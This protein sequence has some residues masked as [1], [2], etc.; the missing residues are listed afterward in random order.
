MVSPGS[1]SPAKRAAERRRDS[2][3]ELLSV[4]RPCAVP[5]LHHRYMDGSAASSAGGV[6]KRPDP[7]ALV[8]RGARLAPMSFAQ[9]R[10]W[11]FEQLHPYRAAYNMASSFRIRGD[12]DLDRLALAFAAVVARHEV[13]RSRFEDKDG[14]GRQVVEPP[15]DVPLPVIDL[16]DEADRE[17]A[18]RRMVRI[19]RTTP[20][21]L[22]K[23]PLLRPS[24]YRLANQEH[25]LNLSVHHI[26]NDGWSYGLLYREVG[27]Y[28]SGSDDLP[29]LPVQFGDFAAWQRETHTPQTLREQLEFW[30]SALAD[31]PMVL[32]LPTDRPRPPLQPTGGAAYRFTLPS[33]LVVS[34]R[35]LAGRTRCTLFMV[36]L[37]ALQVLLGRYSGMERFVVGVPS[38]G[39][40]VPALD[41]LIGL[42]IGVLPVPADLTG[43]PTFEELL[44][45]VR[46]VTL[47]AY[48]H[49]DVPLEMLL[50]ELH[51]PRSLS[52][53]TL[54]QVICQMFEDA[55]RSLNLR[56]AE[57][58]PEPTGVWRSKQDL[59]L[60]FVGRGN[61]FHG[62][63][64]YPPD[65]FD[66]T[67]IQRL[68][69][70]LIAVLREGVAEPGRRL[71]TMTLMDPAERDLVLTNWNDRREGGEDAHCLHE[72]F[73][74]QA[75]RT[76]GA[77]AVRCGSEQVCFGELD[78]RSNRLAHLLA[79][80]GVGPETPV[81]IC[82]DRSIDLVVAILAVLKAG[83]AYVPLEPAYPSLWRR[84]LLRHCAAPIVI[85]THKTMADECQDPARVL[86]L[87]NHEVCRALAS[88]PDQP[89]SVRVLPSALA[90]IIYTSGSTGAPKGVATEHRSVVNRLRWMW[91]EFPFVPDEVC[92]LKTA[93]SFVDSIAEIFGPLLTGHTLVPIPGEDARDTERLLN[94]LGRDGIR[95]IMVVPSLL[96]VLLDTA[97]DLAGR[98]PVLKLWICGGEVLT[99]SLARDF[100]AA[101]P[102]ATLV[103]MYGA[104]ETTVDITYHRVGEADRVPN[105]AIPV[106]RPQTGNRVY[107]LDDSLRPV[108]VGVTGSIYLSGA[109]L[110][111][112][113]YGNPAHTAE[114]F[115]PNPY[116]LPGQRLYHTGDSGRFRPDGAMEFVERTASLAKVR[117]ARVETAHVARVLQEHPGVSEA[118]V[119]IVTRPGARTQLIGYYA[120]R[121][122]GEIGVRA[123]LAERLPDYM[124]PARLVPLELL[125]HLP[126]GK[127]DLRSLLDPEVAAAAPVVETADSG[128]LTGPVAQA[129]CHLLGV[130]VVHRDDNFFTLGGDS[131]TAVRLVARVRAAGIF[132]D[133]RDVFRYLTL[134][135]LDEAW[136]R[137]T[138]ELIALWRGQHS[139]STS[140][141]CSSTAKRLVCAPGKRYSPPTAGNSTLGTGWP[142][143]P[144]AAAR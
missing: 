127:V 7:Q 83:G 6:L 41:E 33:D 17:I 69:A 120:G 8:R 16:R 29:E 27:A 39:R 124:I 51:P 137:R 61:N 37:A 139:S 138:E 36:T 4:R 143:W 125:P 126:N 117:G 78:L 62:L 115:L 134:Q 110:V 79:T 15:M 91:Q 128:T 121:E 3:R 49:A 18:W 30:T 122:I 104:S 116:G 108:P 26:A 87:D 86:F 21:D 98:V 40:P 93:I 66:S 101:M 111:R 2:I 72:M 133:L 53:S 96:R 31:Y 74:A 75:S 100:A 59:S 114:C 55:D 12:L 10:L 52:R 25:V 136:S 13:L 140:T 105:A 68:V 144:Q 135:E 9:E 131:L 24:L 47:A 20:F 58:K 43:D 35:S 65:L 19:E 64:V 107:V 1:L 77:I 102:G 42:F 22:C 129:C 142:R 94:V 95:R 141:D 23:P 89:P 90:Y 34:M 130:K 80:Y 112:G 88:Q 76:P 44:R 54:V 38:V 63:V 103:N 14:Y 57:V 71:S 118:V 5:G 70:H 92:C 32:E 85:A 56:G 11:F 50:D 106:G 113:Y 99:G 48:D 28:Y 97:D 109:N 119:T 46:K 81:G 82:L 84:E 123:W 67:T 73:A 45:R 132:A 60:Q